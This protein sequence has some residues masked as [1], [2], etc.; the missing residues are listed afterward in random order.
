MKSYKEIDGW[1]DFEGIYEHMSNILEDHHTFIE[2]GVWKGKSICFLGQL[3]RIKDKKVKVYAVDT[4][5]GTK[6][7]EPHQNQ[8]EEIGGS[9]LPIFEEN[10]KKLDLEDIITPIVKESVEAAKDFEDE[11][12]AAMFIDGDHSYEGVMADLEAWYPK[13]CYNGWILGHDY[14]MDD[15]KNAVHDYF[16]KIHKRV[17]GFEPD[18][19]GVKKG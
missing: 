14:W 17:V 13:I 2:V 19:W 16:S 4:F 6:N 10:L 7:E 8:I 18:C 5:E 9:T 12:V 11:T 15:V 3:L 1:F